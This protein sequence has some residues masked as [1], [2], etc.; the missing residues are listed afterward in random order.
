VTV[1]RL[2]ALKS[3]GHFA[4]P[5]SLRRRCLL[6]ED[7]ADHRYESHPQQ[8]GVWEFN[9]SKTLMS[10][11]AFLDSGYMPCAKKAQAA[12]NMACARSEH[13]PVQFYECVLRPAAGTLISRPNPNARGHRPTALARAARA[14]H[15]AP[16]DLRRR[17]PLN[18]HNSPKDLNRSVP[19]D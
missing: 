1:L 18:R 9:V 3:S 12:I 10:S 16:T 7:R 8:Y 2:A 14:Y 13:A 5:T 15:L 6:A 11:D 17:W 19:G 4:S